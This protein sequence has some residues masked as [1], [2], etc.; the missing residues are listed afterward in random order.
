MYD[1]EFSYRPANT[2]MTWGTASVPEVARNILNVDENL[3]IV[4]ENGT[5]VD[6]GAGIG[7]TLA[8]L[9][10]I[11]RPDIS[12]ISLDLGYGR[13]QNRKDVESDLLITIEQYEPCQQIALKWQ[14]SW[15]QKRIS[16]LMEKIPLEDNC[17]D[18][19]ISYAAMPIYSRN[20]VLAL[21][22]AT[23]I[24]KPGKTGVFGPMP[25]YEFEDWSENLDV[26]RDNGIIQSWHY[27]KAEVPT[28]NGSHES[29]TTT[30]DKPIVP[31]QHN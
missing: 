30:I 28:P 31:Q 3:N 21:S 7:L 24:M 29:Y 1:L 20:P 25:E 23:R 26:A 27:Q 9:I 15:Y 2:H 5:V 4:P 11:L 10:K 12:T 19:V 22:E 14:P 8:S 18:L 17:A 13:L 6:L 16:A